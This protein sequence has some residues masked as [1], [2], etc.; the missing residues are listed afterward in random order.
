MIKNDLVETIAAKFDL[1]LNLASKIVQTLLDEIVNGLV[2]DS[3]IE[4]R[5]FGV[6][7][8][9]QQRSRVITLPSGKKVT[10]PAQKVIT[11]NP[12]PTVKKKLNPPTKT[13]TKRCRARQGNLPIA[14]SKF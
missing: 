6:F 8:L 5:R 12:S 11:F 10:R 3:R 4:L 13:T 9:K 1:S 14:R 7:G 2:S